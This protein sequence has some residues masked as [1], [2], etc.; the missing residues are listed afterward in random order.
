VS[1]DVHCFQKAAM[2]SGLTYV[3][4]TLFLFALEGI[5]INPFSLLRPMRSSAQDNTLQR[6]LQHRVDA[7]PVI[8]CRHNACLHFC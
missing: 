1:K 4:W 6:L 8:V 2:A 5:L 7:M 3:C